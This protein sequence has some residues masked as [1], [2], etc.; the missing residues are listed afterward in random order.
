MFVH[1]RF[2]V[3]LLV[4]AVFNPVFAD[5]LWIPADAGVVD[6]KRDFGAVGDGV[7]DDTAAVQKAITHG[8][9]QPGRYASPPFVY[10]PVGTYKISGPLESKVGPHGWS[11]GWRAGMLLVGESQSRSIIQLADKAEGFGDAEKPMAVVAS[12]SESDK[13]TKPADAPLDGRGNRAF[14]HSVINLT[15]DTGRGNP[16]AIALDFIANNRGTVRDVTLR[17]AD[18]AGFCGL[19]LERHWPGPALIA[20]VTVDGFD[21]GVRVEHYQYGMTFEHLTLRNQNKVGLRNT[22][23]M[24]AIRGLKSENRVPA[25]TTSGHALVV[26]LDSD[27]TGGSSDQTAIRGDG[28]LYLRRVSVAGYGVAVEN[29]KEKIAT[30]GG[31]AVVDV[32]ATRRYAVG[33]AKAEPLDLPI[34]E[35]PTFTSASPTDWVNVR[36]FE[37]RAVRGSWTDKDGKTHEG[38]VDW[39]PAI[40][41]AIDSGKPIVYLPNGPYRVRQQIVLRGNVRMM[42]GFQSSITPSEPMPT[43]GDGEGRMGRKALIRFEGGHAQG[44][45]LQ[46]LRVDGIVEH[47]GKTPLVLRHLDFGGYRNTAEGSGDV[48]VED[49]IGAPFHVH[50]PQRFFGRQINS[51]FG[52]RPLF[53]NRGGT[54]WLLGFKTEGEMTCLHQTAGRTEILGALFYPLK[55]RNPVG[56]A[57]LNEGGQ[58]SGSI[59]MNSKGYKLYLGEA[60][61]DARRAVGWEQIKHRAAALLVSDVP[62]R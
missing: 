22:N 59:C 30:K 6:V 60:V 23:N 24:L 58:F 2:V 55:N 42:M 26:L 39:T 5:R 62:T 46:H 34:E 25:L 51:E 41:A 47:A 12:G 52:E 4:Y 43:H 18:G 9:S 50:H 29:G 17:S 61:E 35:S 48:F 33:D 10:F 36:S 37:D 44:T 49:T 7:A 1:Q 21:F 27:L 38:I 19:R 20:N 14:R 31:R 15:I 8:L 53:E 28:Q 57:V 16:G 32:H 45:V 54:V 3:L 56:P 40:Q 11:G 13:T